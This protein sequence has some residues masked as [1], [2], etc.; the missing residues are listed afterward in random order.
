[1]CSVGGTLTR[2]FF[3]P[4]VIGLT[5]LKHKI[6]IYANMPL[7]SLSPGMKLFVNVAEV[8]VG[9]VGVDLSGG[10]IGVP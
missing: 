2:S 9:D 8:F 7:V 6:P 10:N 3:L 5:I 4:R 1:M